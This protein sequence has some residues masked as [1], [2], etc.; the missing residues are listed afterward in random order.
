ML[1][2]PFRS[3]EILLRDIGNNEYIFKKKFNPNSKHHVFEIKIPVEL[4]EYQ[5]K[6]KM[7]QDELGGYRIFILPLSSFLVY[8]LCGVFGE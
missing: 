4:G 2:Q 7:F 5:N 8:T 1:S 6:K 3:I